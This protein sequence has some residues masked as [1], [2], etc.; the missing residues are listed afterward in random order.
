MVSDGHAHQ[1]GRRTSPKC[2]IT[3]NQE[4]RQ[5]RQADWLRHVSDEALRIAKSAATHRRKSIA[6]SAGTIRK[7][8]T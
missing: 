5:D 3:G 1:C 8:Q 6:A 2:I 7:L 4:L